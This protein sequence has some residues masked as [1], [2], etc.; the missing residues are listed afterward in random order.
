VSFFPFH[1]T[2]LIKRVSVS[3][4]YLRSGRHAR[5]CFN[6]RLILFRALRTVTRAGAA[7]LLNT[8]RIQLPAYD[9]VLHANVLH[10]ASAKQNDRVFLEV[11]PFAGNIGGYF[12]AVREAD[13]GDFSDGGVRLSRSLG[14]HLGADASFEG[15]GI[16]RRAIFE[17]IKTARQR[18][19]FR[20]RRFLL[21]PS[22]GELIDGGHFLK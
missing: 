15:R 11:V 22:L 8:A 17:C 18:E 20:L 12:H 3:E 5:L 21:T 19:H 4:P 2:A 16:K 13:A 6:G 1:I 14:G 9:C 10:A 7:A